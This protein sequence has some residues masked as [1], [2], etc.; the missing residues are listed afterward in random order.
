MWFPFRVI[1]VAEA[2]CQFEKVKVTFV[3]YHRFQNYS[4]TCIHMPELFLTSLIRFSK[5]T[6]VLW[7]CVPSV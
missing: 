7:G 5:R 4:V 6:E 1:G 3:L 2:A